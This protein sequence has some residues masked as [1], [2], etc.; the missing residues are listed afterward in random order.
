MTITKNATRA[1]AAA[2]AA[3]LAVTLT[4]TP[5][6]AGQPGHRPTARVAA[7]ASLPVGVVGARLAPADPATAAAMQPAPTVRWPA[8]SAS[9]MP[10]RDGLSRAGDLPVWVGS[11]TPN[12]VHVEVLG[13]DAAD[14]AGVTGVLVRLTPQA[15]TRL[16]VRVDYSGFSTAYGGDWSRRLRL[17]TLPNCVVTTP[18]V[19]ACRVVAV[20]ASTNDTVHQTL[21]ATTDVTGEGAVLATAAGASSDAGDYGASSVSAASTWQAGGSSGDFAWT[22]PLRVP[23]GLGGPQPDLAISYSAQSVDG[24]TASTNAQPS[25][26][27]EGFDLPD[28]FIERKYVSCADDGHT[29]SGDQCWKYDNASMVL[30]G[31]ATDLVLDDADGAWH[32]RNADGARVEK[33]TNPNANGDNNNEYWKVTTTDGTQYFFGYH[34]LPGWTAGKELTNSVLTLPVAGD[35]S[36]EPCHS[37]SGFGPSFCT[38]AWRW[39]LDYVVDT[40]GNAATFW[41]TNETNRYARN[42]VTNPSVSYDRAAW[43]NRIAYGQRSG[44]LFTVSAPMSVEVSTAERCIPNGSETCSTLSAGN[45]AAWPDVPF[46]QICSSTTCT[47]TTPTFF[48]RRRL[49]RIV[50]K[51]GGSAVDQWDLTQSF[52]ATG[53]GTSPSLW[54]NKISHTGKAS[55]AGVAGTAPAL[56][57]SFGGIQLDN[58][59]DALEGIAPMKKWRVRTITTEPGSLITVNYAP[60]N[61]VRSALPTPDTNTKRCFPSYWTPDGAVEPVLDW[62]HKYV[63]AQVLTGDGT[64]GADTIQTDYTYGADAAWHYDDDDGISKDKYRT[65]SGWRGYQTLTTNTGN[66]VLGSSRLSTRSLFMRGMHGDK[67]SGGGTKAVTVTDSQGGVLTD[68]TQLAG[69]LREQ[70]TNNG[71]GG[72]EVNGSIYD[73]WTLQTASRSQS[74]GV[75]RAHFVRTAS[76]QSRVALAAGGSRRSTTTSTFDSAYGLLTQTHDRGDDA[77]STDDTCTRIEYARNASTNIVDLIRR[78]ET[79]KVAC[80]ATPSRPADVVA[81]T[82]TSFDGGAFGATPSKGD[83]TRAERLASYSGSTPVYQTVSTTTYDSL[84]RPTR[85][86]DA[87]GNATTTAY[88]PATGGPLAQTVV[89]GP[90]P[91]GT[92]TGAAQRTTT[93]FVAAWQSPS[94]TVDVNG[95][96]VDMTYDPLG[97]RTAVWL[98]N[99]SKSLNQSANVK[100]AY[101]TLAGAPWAVATQK[102]RDDGITYT[103]TF[104]IYDALLRQ[105]QTQSPGPNGGRIITDT[106]YDSRGLAARQL[107]DYYNADAPSATLVTLNAGASPSQRQLTYDGV[108]RQ[109]VDAFVVNNVEQWRTTTAYGGD[110]VTVDRPAGATDTTEISDTRDHVIERRE[111]DGDTPAGPFSKTTYTHDLAGRMTSLNDDAG[112]AWRYTFDLR[113]RQTASDDPDKG[114]LDSVYD[115]LDRL[116]ST[117]D[118]RGITLV[119]TYDTIGRKTGLYNGSVL[120]ANQVAGWTYDAISGAQGQPVASTRYVGGSAGSAYTT[121]VVSYDSMYRATRTDVIIPAVETGLSGTYTSTAAYNIDGTLQ[122]ATWPAAGGLPAEALTYGYNTL[123]QPTTLTGS[124]GLVRGTVYSNLGDPQQYTLGVSSVAKVAQ[125]TMHYETGTRRLSELIGSDET[126]PTASTDRLYTYDP[127]GNVKQINETAGSPDDVQCFG[128]DGHRRLTSAWTPNSADCVQAP[129]VAALG[130]PAPYWLSWTYNTLGLRTGQTDHRGGG[131][132]ATTYAYPMATTPRPHAVSTTTTTGVGTKSFGYDAAGNTTSHPSAVTGASQTLTWDPEGHAAGID[133]STYLYDADGDRLIRRDPGVTTLYLGS[134]E[135]HRTNGGALTAERHYIH[136]GVTVAVRTNAGLS[137]LITDPHGTPYVSIDASA[138]AFVRRYETPFGTRRGTAPAWPSQRAFVGG[139]D[140]AATALVHLGAREYDPALGRFLSVDPVLD[141]DDPQSLAAYTYAGNNPVTESDPT[142]L[143]RMPEGGGVPHPPVPAY[144]ATELCAKTATG[145]SFPPPAPPITPK[146]KSWWQRN[147][148]DHVPEPIRHAASNTTHALG[149]AWSAVDNTVGRW[150][151]SPLWDIASIG[152]AFFCIACA[153]AMSALAAAHDVSE[154]NYL[155]AAANILGAATGGSSILIRRVVVKKAER[156]LTAAAARAK[157]AENAWANS[158]HT[159][160]DAGRYGSAIRRSGFNAAKRNYLG[161]QVAREAAERMDYLYLTL[162][163]YNLGLA[164]HPDEPDSH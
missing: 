110:R 100:Y 116:T 133:G 146:K 155:G 54:L 24:R 6:I 20:I 77:L 71:V 108:G 154:R 152:V 141:A 153:A 106:S 159:A 23:P 85:V 158:A 58:R 11:A 89:T 139:V 41:Y 45:K 59:V 157:P 43:L 80:S 128:Y 62:F 161:L 162:Q 39:Y 35:D 67:K 25:W 10:A 34:Q 75:T 83:P 150:T 95:K 102:L 37:A 99:R 61:C 132:V 27:G 47:Q 18:A 60:T 46:D 16:S 130:G 55:G 63:V 8:G 98:A 94:A 65:W 28:S 115:D 5:A 151:E 96:R 125:I 13:R 50:T 160:S 66:T 87:L 7:I 97:R 33:L 143:M 149:K 22:Y 53:D 32:T 48:S 51:A 105:R 147:I 42:G 138:Q 88:T 15:A 145:P 137:W 17:V 156:Q 69:F 127:A 40:N 3:I 19:D 4:D 2:T 14:A 142:G 117:T 101:T 30:N 104:T 121:K 31:H 1:V 103:V 9:V 113:G 86:T 93:T 131:D 82:R 134:T 123:D 38:Q 26:V 122:L 68:T 56:N 107:A 12:A 119:S 81:D 36:G 91:D 109:T 57:V 29:S 118:A 74:W 111:Y 70:I 148:A 120:P 129:S 64:G 84:G 44:S 90:D 72:A 164:T 144:C 140:D 73:P 78:S 49:T 79:V 126:N 21:S 124:T 92:G 52:P 114:H 112:N 163:S 135:V 136:N 76:T